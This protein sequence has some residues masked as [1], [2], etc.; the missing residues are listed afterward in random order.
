[1][2]ASIKEAELADGNACAWSSDGGGM[3]Q[4]QRPQSCGGGA[5]PTRL[6]SCKRLSRHCAQLLPAVNL[7]YCDQEGKTRQP[8]SQEYLLA[9]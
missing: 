5:C 4:S 8:T 2:V 3:Q 9:L 7:P 6:G 1:M